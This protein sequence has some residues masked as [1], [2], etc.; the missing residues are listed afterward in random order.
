MKAHSTHAEN[1]RSQE[2]F[3]RRWKR[4]ALTVSLF[5]L[6][7][8]IF[9][10]LLPVAVPLSL[11][12]NLFF[13]ANFGLLRTYLFILTYLWCE[14]LGLLALFV[15][16]LL[17]LPWPREGR[18]G[19]LRGT[20]FLQRLW[21]TTLYRA[22]EVFFSSRTSLEGEVPTAGTG[23]LL[24]FMRHASTADTMFPIAY[25]AN[26]YGWSLR[27]VIK[28]E[29][30]L[31]PCVD[32]TCQ[33][34]P[35][36][37]VERGGQQGAAEAQRVVALLAGMGSDE[38]LVIYPEGSRFSPAKKEAQLAR[39]RARGPAL[40][41]RLAEELECTLS[42]LRAGSLALLA[43]NRGA[44]LLLIGHTGLEAAENMGSL[45]RGRSVGQAIGVRTWF[46]PYEKLPQDPQQREELL[47]ATWKEL[48]RFISSHSSRA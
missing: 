45:V 18:A 30:L 40:A 35:N 44:S 11:L 21:G 15:W 14:Q 7:T 42:P 28:R 48:D 6:A 5:F 34:L 1:A 26:Q 47:A 8:G 29:L 43:N 22:Y 25:L 39:L 3:L 46:I 27:Y 31:D 23:P 33:R 4:R 2:G 13:P 19:L 36:C 32:V 37:F 9:T 38:A 41:L 24:V 10:A 20:R 16:W 12:L 17:S